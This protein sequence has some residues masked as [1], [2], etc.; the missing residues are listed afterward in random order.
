MIYLIFSIST[1]GL[2]SQSMGIG[3]GTTAP[4]ATA[5]F[6]VSDTSRGILIPRMTLNQRLSIQNPAEGLMVYQTDSASSIYLFSGGAWKTIYSYDSTL[7]IGENPIEL[8]LFS[9]L[10]LLEGTHIVP[11]NQ[12]WKIVSIQPLPGFGSLQDTGNY[13]GCSQG[14][15]GWS[16][17]KCIYSVPNN[18]TLLSIDKGLEF[19]GSF[20]SSAVID[21]GCCPPC[22]NCPPKALLTY[23]Y[24]SNINLSLPYWLNEGNE[25]TVGKFMRIQ[26]E[27][28]K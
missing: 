21:Q 6:E 9:T 24:T 11:P 13:L 19:A 26:V 10:P 2:F 3:I 22:G 18:I 27:R 5:A 23:N 7:S 17:T 20:S 25:I 4:H 12:S 14:S 15:P 8:K 1:H 16:T 28:Y